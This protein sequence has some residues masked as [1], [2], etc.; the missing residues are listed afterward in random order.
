MKIIWVSANTGSDI[1]GTGSKDLPYKTIDKALTVFANQDQ[2]R[3]LSGG[4]ELYT[5]TDSIVISGLE[6]SIFAEDPLG[7]SIQPQKTTA[8]WAGL[9]ILNSPRFSLIGF[10]VLQALA[11]AGNLGGICADSVDNFLCYTCAVHDFDCPS[12]DVK[13]IFASGSGR[14]ENCQVYNIIAGGSMLYGIHTEGVDIID[15]EAYELSGS[16]HVEP[17]LQDIY[18]PP[19]PGGGIFLAGT[20]GYSFAGGLLTQLFT[21]GEDSYD[22]LTISDSDIWLLALNLGSYNLHHYDGNSWTP[23]LL[24]PTGILTF[25]GGAASDDVWAGGWDN[26]GGPI[27]YH[28]DGLDWSSIALPGDPPSEFAGLYC[29]LALSTN[30]VYI[31]GGDMAEGQLSLLYHWDGATL[32]VVGTPPIPMQFFDMWGVDSNNIWLIGSSDDDRIVVKFNGSS[33]TTVVDTASAPW[34]GINS[35]LSVFGTSANDLWFG[36]DG[37]GIGHWDGAICS[38]ITDPVPN[39]DLHSWRGI[40][41]TSSDDIYI[42]GDNGIEL[43]H[44]RYILH[45][46]GDALTVS[47]SESSV[48]NTSFSRVRVGNT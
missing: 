42:C 44:A 39:L 45:W 18:T 36:C 23:Y 35:V 10:N 28:W 33:Y 43:N 7:V 25:V 11:P 37:V 47:Y 1:T 4:G 48:S 8:H 2:I 41:G 9:A 27:L 31:G 20:S 21:T 19:P 40:C 30:N 46:N 34:M 14:I 15:C 12:G 3:F 13:G 22:I 32:S 6:G 16:G 38:Q 26:N 5:P 29:M 24:N 17:I